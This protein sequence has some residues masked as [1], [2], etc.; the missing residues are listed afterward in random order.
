MNIKKLLAEL[1]AVKELYEAIL[2]RIEEEMDKMPEGSLNCKRIGACTYF[3]HYTRDKD[4]N[5]I[6]RYLPEEEERFAATLKRKRFLQL[7]IKRLRISIKAIGVFLKTFIIYDPDE[8]LA[9]LPAAFRDIGYKADGSGVSMDWDNAEY[10]KNELYKDGLVYGTVGGLMVRS[11]SEAI[12]AGFLEACNIP[13]R[14]EAALKLGERVY[15]PDFTIMR[16]RDN[17]ILY[18][19]HFGMM[20]DEEYVLRAER[21][22]A[23]YRKYD[24]LPLN[25]L[26]TTY[27]T[28]KAPLNVNDIRSIINAFII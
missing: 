10:E 19:E 9:K 14:Y 1:S 3:Y 25:Q 20:D 26:I 11:K 28:A 5:K 16:P 22:L 21:K 18:W 13:F 6:Q 15:Y 2:Q 24:I 12:I 7:S 4:G 17:K 8:I 27:E 23:V